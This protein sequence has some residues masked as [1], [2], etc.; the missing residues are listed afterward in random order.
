[1]LQEKTHKK[2]KETI[3]QGPHQYVWSLQRM[4]SEEK[5]ALN[6]MNPYSHRFWVQESIRFWNQNLETMPKYITRRSTATTRKRKAMK[7]A[8]VVPWQCKG[9]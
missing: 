1:M 5:F 8:T 7:W 6:A 4:D 9:S 3:G 2:W